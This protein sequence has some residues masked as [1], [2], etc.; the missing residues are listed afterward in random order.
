[1]QHLDKYQNLQKLPALKILCTTVLPD[2]KKI[3]IN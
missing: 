1:M 3:P 2:R